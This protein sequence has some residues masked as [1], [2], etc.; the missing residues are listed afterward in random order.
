[1][2][3][4][5]QWLNAFIFILSGENR[6]EEKKTIQEDIQPNQFSSFWNKNQCASEKVN[7]LFV[8]KVIK[9]NNEKTTTA[10]S[11]VKIKRSVHKSNDLLLSFQIKLHVRLM[12]PVFLFFFWYFLISS[13][14]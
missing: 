2:N 1:M 7:D 4:A 12:Q 8:F 5:G 13:V 9:K 14:R 11:L 3:A 10:A 6:K